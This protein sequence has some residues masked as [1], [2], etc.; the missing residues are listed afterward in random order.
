M[1]VKAKITSPRLAITKDKKYDL[2]KVVNNS[3]VIRNERLAI[4]S[5]N[6]NKFEPVGLFK[7]LVILR[8][9]FTIKHK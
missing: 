3:Y 9:L 6:K 1:K 4:I 2:I 8:T 5:I 7:I